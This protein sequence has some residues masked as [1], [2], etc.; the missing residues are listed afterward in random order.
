M[1][2]KNPN[3][4]NGVVSTKV[5]AAKNAQPTPQQLSEMLLKANERIAALEAKLQQLEAHFYVAPNGD[6]EISSATAVRIVAGAKVD[7]SCDH[8]IEIL[9]AQS[10]KLRD[11]NGN[12]VRFAADGISE[13]AAAKHAVNAGTMEANA[14]MLS[15]NSGMSKFSGVVKC[16]TII[17][18]SVVGSSYTPGAGNIW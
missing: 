15:V 18:D 12:Q 6:V 5:M 1:L 13:Q 16:S 4:A 11:Q 8:A 10:V 9:G 3:R 2:S 7:I 14:G 17:A